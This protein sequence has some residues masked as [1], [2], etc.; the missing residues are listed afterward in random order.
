[1]CKRRWKK[2]LA[3]ILTLALALTCAMPMSVQAGDP[4][5]VPGEAVTIRLQD[6]LERKTSFNKGWK[7]YLGDIPAASQAGYDDSSWTSVDV[8]H[9]FSIIQEFTK[10]NAEGESGFLPGGT[11]WYRKSFAMPQSADGKKVVLSFDGVYNNAY[12]YVNGTKVGEHFYGYTNF[13]FDI[14]DY[15]V[16][17]GATMNVIAVKVQ[18]II[19]SSRWYSGSGIYRDVDLIVTNPV[20]V[21]YNGTR[22]TTPNLAATKGADG[23]VNVEIEVQNEAQQA[24]TIQVNS[25]IYDASGIQVG[26]EGTNVLEL[27]AGATA[28][29]VTSPAV[30]NPSLWSVDSPAQY[31]VETT[32]RVGGEIVD[33]YETSFGFRWFS[34]DLTKGFYLNGSPL[35]LYGVCLHHDQGALGSAAY[36]DAMY[37]QLSIMKDMGC[38]SIRT[39]HNTVDEDFIDICNELGLIVI[40]EAFDGW[41]YSKNANTHDFGEYFDATISESNQLIGASASMTWAEFAIKSMVKRDRNDPSV[42]AWSI[43]NEI[44]QGASI[45]STYPGKA[46]NLINWAKAVDPTRPATIGANQSP[47]YTGS[48]NLVDVMKKIADNGGLV[49]LN[50]VGN[51]NVDWIQ[52]TY[53]DAGAPFYISESSSAV[54]SRGIYVSQTGNAQVDGKYH[55]TSYDTSNVSWGHT[56]HDA[57]YTAIT[58]DDVFGEYVW[59]GFD[60]IGEPTPWNPTELGVSQTSGAYPNTSYFGIVDTSGFEKDTYY[61]YRSQWNHDETTLHLVTAWDSDNM[62]TYDGKTPVWVYSN[63]PVVK[64]YRDGALIGTATRAVRTTGVGHTYYTYTTQSNNTDVC[65]TSSGS[66]STALYSVFDV[67][68]QKGTLSAKA[69]Q[70]DGTT[71]IALTGNSGRSIITTPETPAKLVAS[72]NK[73]NVRADGS[74]FAY[75][76]VDVTDANG[77]FDTT[78]VNTVNVTVTGEGVIAGVDNGD[79]AS[80]NK[81]QSSTVLSSDRKSASIKTYAGKALVII[82][83]TETAGTIS[84][85]LSSSG[86]TGTSVSLVSTAPSETTTE[87]V[88]NYTMVNDYSVL[89]G[90]QPQL[91]TSA[92]VRLTNGTVLAA[93]IQWGSVG[94]EIY[95][96]PGDYNILGSLSVEGYESLPV[97]CR[98]H[99]IPRVVAMRNIAAVTTLGSSPQLPDVVRGVLADGALAGDFAVRWNLENLSFDAIGAIVTVPGTVTVLGSFA[100]PVT[101]SVRVAPANVLVGSENV[102]PQISLIEQDIPSGS[103]SDNI[104]SLYDTATQVA[105]STSSRWTNYAYRDTRNTA[106]LTLTWLSPVSFKSVRLWWFHDNWSATEAQNVVFSTS[107]D[108]KTYTQLS[109]TAGDK[110]STYNLGWARTYTFA[111]PVNTYYLRITMTQKDGSIAGGEKCCIGLTEIECMSEVYTAQVGMADTPSQLLVDGAPLA[112]FAP[113]TFAYTASGSVV[114]AAAAEGENVAFTVLPA[115]QSV[116][117]ILTLSED[118]NHTK[119]YA[120]T[121]SDSPVCMH[122]N[123]ELRDLVTMTCTKDGYSGDR[124]CRDCGIKLEDGQVIPAKGHGATEVRDV[125]TATC[126]QQGYSGNTYCTDCGEI[127]ARGYT[128]QKAAHSWDGGVVETPATETA[129]GLMRYTC[130]VCGETR[131]EVIP[132]LTVV[133]KIPSVSLSVSKNSGKIKMSAD[134]SES[135]GDEYYEITGQGLLYIMQYKLGSRSLYLNTPGRTNVTYR[136][137]SGTGLYNY[138]FSPSVRNLQYAMRA[139]ITYIDGDGNLQYA[140]SNTV[141]KSYNQLP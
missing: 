127:V 11:G 6:A 85:A 118:G 86:L 43:G 27:A 65:S 36:Y 9:D 23:T 69:F 96:T 82:R 19:G 74:S 4:G 70:A 116:V 136:T 26:S 22:V 105:N 1:M 21:A 140:Y 133:K 54:N 20:H 80:V 75:I 24:K 109:H 123:T 126:L 15:L 55:L 39:S 99:V 137:L 48:G 110:E 113:E 13:A 8:P 115:Y 31:T 92:S 77:N 60:Y 52:Q 81:F 33:I 98:L 47:Y 90:T 58:R 141:V 71:E 38:N 7:F 87:G 44:Q 128:I 59:T 35:K 29:V 84:V 100:L 108:G 104:H 5:T 94:S 66:G 61:L 34:F 88:Q 132:K 40:E 45:D 49:G 131:T 103:Q 93:S 124:Y 51:G 64:L 32:L 53:Q 112:G 28:L 125:V 119:T 56:A 25:I 67:A 101:A 122:Q 95:D 139:Y 106:A 14:S 17:D 73:T 134:F 37:R 62:Y 2:T 68:Y 41:S 91:Q 138:S 111:E 130:T 102:T 129:A 76:E 57:I 12:V 50:Y 79:Q 78:A 114:T 72:V 10:N 63:A 83:T 30:S 18:N 135:M 97:S 117:R 107:T 121:L 120:V 89:A 3:V 16:Y 46:M 42:I